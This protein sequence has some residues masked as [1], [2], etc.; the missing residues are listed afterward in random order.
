MIQRDFN[1]TS[2]IVLITGC[3]TGIGRDL[4]QR[5]TRAGYTVVATARKMETLDNVQAALKLPLDVTQPESIRQAIERIVQQFGRIDALIN[6]AGYA[7]RGAVEEV[8]IEQAQAMFDTNV[9]GVMRMIQAVVPFMR[10]QGSGRIINISSVVG[11]LVTPANGVYSASKFAL[12]ALSDAL[13]LELAPFGILV[14]LIE[15]GSIKTQFHATVEANA[16][17]IF[18]NSGSPYQSLYRQ[19]EQV[20][21]DMRRQEAGP[22][23]VS[24]IVQQAINTS[25]PKARYLAGFPFSGKLVLHLGDF[26]WDLVVR[27]MF[28]ITPA[29]R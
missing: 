18:A 19:Y 27:R 29:I 13:R 16:R 1:L 14:V 12:E 11:R 3:S 8:P 17:T 10:Q 6:N 9:F 21:A 7:V 20:T 28:K 15:P 5:L 23:V 22:E 26:V 25:R 2:R 24:K 4:A